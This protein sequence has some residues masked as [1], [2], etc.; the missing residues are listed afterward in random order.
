MT[1]KHFKLNLNKVPT[2]RNVKLCHI[3]T[4]PM[5]HC[6]WFTSYSTKWPNKN[7]RNGILDAQPRNERR[8][9]VSCLTDAGEIKARSLLILS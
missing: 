9:S 2:H 6:Y 8:G 5:Q 7:L 3:R 4:L 1:A